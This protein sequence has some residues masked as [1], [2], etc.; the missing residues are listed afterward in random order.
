M[1]L[2]QVAPGGQWDGKRQSRSVRGCQWLGGAAHRMNR[3]VHRNGFE[4]SSFSSNR[5]A[6]VLM[7]VNSRPSVSMAEGTDD[8]YSSVPVTHWL[9]CQV[10]S[11][12][13]SL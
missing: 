2:R 8:H 9:R 12:S 10:A 5:S 3:A 13:T 6:S 7:T 1:C 4:L 11:A